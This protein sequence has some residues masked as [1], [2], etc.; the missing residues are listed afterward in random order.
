V[1]EGWTQVSTGKEY[2]PGREDVG[3]RLRV[4]VS[5]VALADGEVLAGPVSIFTDVV[6]QAPSAPPKRVSV[7][8][9]HC[10]W[11]TS[12]FLSSLVSCI[13]RVLP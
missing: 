3:C 7:L 13:R 10:L 2:L 8:L 5:A 6:L 1:P 12:F 4:Q 11:F 9:F